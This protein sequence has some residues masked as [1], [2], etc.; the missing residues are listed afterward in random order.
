MPNETVPPFSFEEKNDNAV[1]I[2]VIDGLKV[3]RT[4][5][6]MFKKQ[7]SNAMVQNQ[8]ITEQAIN[9]S[10]QMNDSKK[11]YRFQIKRLP[12]RINPDKCK[13]EFEKEKVVI[14][15]LKSEAETWKQFSESDYETIHLV[16]S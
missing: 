4:M 9:F 3:H 10:I 13:V 14:T 16:K 5:S 6:S 2:L 12:T 8:I 7:P 15:L 11:L 1:F